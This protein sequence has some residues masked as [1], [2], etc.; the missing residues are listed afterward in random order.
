MPLWM[1]IVWMVHAVVVMLE[2]CF[3]IDVLDSAAAADVGAGLRQAQATLTQP[4]LV[5]VLVSCVACWLCT[6]GWSA[7]A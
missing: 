7:A 5:I 2:W 6:T 4:W 3:T 1:A